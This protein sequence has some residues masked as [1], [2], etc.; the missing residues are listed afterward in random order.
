[1]SH[2]VLC[3]PGTRMK[4]TRAA[5][6][7][8]VELRSDFSRKFRRRAGVF[9]LGH[10]QQPKSLV[11]PRVDPAVTPSHEAEIA[12]AVSVALPQRMLRYATGL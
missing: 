2:N 8:R 3:D 12:P 11:P 4:D 9:S 10:P 1:M 6:V 7:R 5:P